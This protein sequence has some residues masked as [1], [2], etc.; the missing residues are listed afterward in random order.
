MY[1][2]RYATG[3]FQPM[4]KYWSFGIIIPKLVAKKRQTK[5]VSNQQSDHHWFWTDCIPINY[6]TFQLVKSL[7][8]DHSWRNLHVAPCFPPRGVSSSMW[9]HPPA[10]SA[11]LY[12]TKPQRSSDNSA[13]STWMC[14]L[15]WNR[16]SL[17]S[18]LQPSYMLDI[19]WYTPII[20][21]VL[22]QLSATFNHLLQ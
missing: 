16:K 21:G 7:G 3:W 4:Q 18:L 10:G 14:I 12:L 2:V 13:P 22:L 6:H 15:L 5:H 9:R 11:E 8:L 1:T 20:D 19:P 17:I